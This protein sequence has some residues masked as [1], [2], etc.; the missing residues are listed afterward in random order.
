MK[1]S[2]RTMEI[3]STLLT[4]PSIGGLVL[5]SIKHVA[6]VEQTRSVTISPFF[7]SQVILHTYTNV[8]ARNSMNMFQIDWILANYI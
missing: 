4:D 2:M 7:K 3:D 1:A 8:F 5:E 6:I